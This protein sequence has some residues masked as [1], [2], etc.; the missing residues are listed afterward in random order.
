MVDRLEIMPT[1]RDVTTV[2]TYSVPSGR[3]STTH[4]REGVT[5][6]ISPVEVYFEYI[7]M[8]AM[9]QMVQL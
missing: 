2:T 8:Q 3:S 9:K 1:I 4:S 7:L 5:H 6:R